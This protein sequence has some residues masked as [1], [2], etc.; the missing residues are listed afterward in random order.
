MVDNT[1]EVRNSSGISRT[2]STSHS[3]I[4]GRQQASWLSYGALK[5][6]D[7]L[8]SICALLALSPLLLLVGLLIKLDSAGPIIFSQTR[9]GLDKRPFKM[10]KFRS[11]TAQHSKEK[12]VQAI[13]NDPRVTRVGKFIRATSIDELP[14]LLNV[15]RGEMSLVGPRPHPTDLDDQFAPK[16]QGYDRRFEGLPGITGLAQVRG[17]RGPTETVAKMKLRIDSDVEYVNNQSIKN[18]VWILLLTVYSVVL[19]QNVRGF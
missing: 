18:Y 2:A 10:F 11:M 8:L 13:E 9:Y 14:Q 19:R 1:Q 16:I 6:L 12:F 17:Y 3:K 5:L 4:N 15:I 7:K